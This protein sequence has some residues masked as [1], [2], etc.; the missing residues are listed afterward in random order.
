MTQTLYIK[1]QMSYLFKIFSRL[2]FASYRMKLRLKKVHYFLLLFWTGL[3]M[4]A[5]FAQYSL[6][7]F[8]LA[9]TTTQWFDQQ[10]GDFNNELLT[11]EY[12]ELAPLTKDNNPYFSADSWNT[13][14]LFYRG[15][16]FRNINFLYNVLDQEV[17]VLFRRPSIYMTLPIRLYL[18]NLDWFE[19]QGLYFVNFH[20]DL[21]NR[22]AGIYHLIYE[23]PRI[24]F[25]EKKQ[26]MSVIENRR[27]EFE[28]FNWFRLC[29]DGPCHPIRSKLTFKKLFPTHKKELRKFWKNSNFGPLKKADFFKLQA[30]GNLCNTFITQ[31]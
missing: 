16:E 28:N 30:L 25:L 6:D 11:G 29:L 3:C 18:E 1:T 9:D 27:I 4:N 20:T 7:D 19:T 14:T 12:A 26:K 31:E 22:P 5:G 23:S 13:A 24:T 21:P 10:I 8:S 15:E 2:Y 17:Y